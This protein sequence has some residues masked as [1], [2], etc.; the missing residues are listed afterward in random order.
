MAD[1]DTPNSRSGTPRKV[2]QPPFKDF[3]GLPEKG[4]KDSKDKNWKLKDGKYY[5][6]KD[7]KLKKDKESKEKLLKEQKEK[8]KHKDKSKEEKKKKE[9][10]K[11]GKIAK[12]NKS[13]VKKKMKTS[14]RTR[15]AK[16]GLFFPVGRIHR[17]L[18]AEVPRNTRVGATAAIYIAAVMEYVIAE[19]LELAGNNARNNKKSRIT[20]RNIQLAIKQDNEL[21]KLITATISQGGVVPQIHKV[22]ESRANQRRQPARDQAMHSPIVRGRQRGDRGGGTPLRRGRSASRSPR[23]S[24][25]RSP[26]RGGRGGVTPRGR[27]A[28]RS[29]SPAAQRRRRWTLNKTMRRA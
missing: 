18:K 8:D 10:G 29:R 14:A 23:R 22:L 21:N 7:E 11:D 24:P 3:K 15:S 17:Q 26:A 2:G 6:E 25:P 20:P 13:D 4:V 9:K 19:V 28:S 5:K 16:A 12:K 27:S 1:R